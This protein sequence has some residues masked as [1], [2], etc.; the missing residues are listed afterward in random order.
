[1]D[2]N[3]I[4]Y[5]LQETNSEKP[6]ESVIEHMKASKESFDD[7]LFRTLR[8]KGMTS[9]ESETRV[10]E[11]KEAYQKLNN[12]SKKN[13]NTNLYMI[14]AFL[15]IGLLIA[16]IVFWVTSIKNDN[17]NVLKYNGIEAAAEA[18]ADA[19]GD[20][21]EANAYVGNE[22]TDNATI[23]AK[24]DIAPEVEE[25][26]KTVVVESTAVAALDGSEAVDAATEATVAN[27]M[28]RSS[29]FFDPSKAKNKIREFL[30]TEDS[31][32]LEKIMTFYSSN[33]YRYW[34]IEDPSLYKI[35]N[36]YLRVWEKIK[37][38]SNGIEEISQ[39]SDQ[40]FKVSG[41]YSYWSIKD[42]KTKTRWATTYFTLDNNYRIISTSD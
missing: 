31:Q 10:K 26:E 19:T 13:S 8:S 37:Y 11:L 7:I 16:G 14:L 33:I 29:S 42:Q 28:D 6:L 32:S 27:S 35:R 4:K 5:I 3:Y 9:S 34:N 36:N 15:A 25:E 40:R 12:N 24:R 21:I 22:D 23:E 2:K 20:A 39:V 17:A 30:R 18:V 41:N 1:M 38:P